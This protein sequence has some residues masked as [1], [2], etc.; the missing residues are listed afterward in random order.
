[1]HNDL[2]TFP[3]WSLPSKLGLCFCHRPWHHV[4]CSTQECLYTAPALHTQAAQWGSPQDHVSPGQML[5]QEKCILLMLLS[6]ISP[7]LKGTSLTKSTWLSLQQEQTKNG[8]SIGPLKTEW[9]QMVLCYSES[10]SI[11]MTWESYSK[12]P[13]NEAGGRK[14]LWF[15]SIWQDG[16]SPSWLPLALPSK[17]D[18]EPPAGSFQPITENSRKAWG[19]AIALCSAPLS[20]PKTKGR[21]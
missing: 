4:L 14:I 5:Q 17:P 13:T 21:G 6:S 19:E 8:I 11:K 2:S 16:W 18:S 15:V 1:M 10:D 12:M 20:V 3:Q 7:S 9:S